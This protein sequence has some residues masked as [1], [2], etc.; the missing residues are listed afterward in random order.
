LGRRAISHLIAFALLCAA[1][2]TAAFAKN[3]AEPLNH[4]GLTTLQDTA[5]GSRLM[6]RFKAKGQPVFLIHDPNL[7][8]MQGDIM[9]FQ[10]KAVL[11]DADV[12]QTLNDEGALGR[13]KVAPMVRLQAKATVPTWETRA[14]MVTGQ[15]EKKAYQLGA[16]L[17]KILEATFGGV[18]NRQQ[19]AIVF[20]G[21][22][23]VL[24]A[25]DEFL[26]QLKYSTV[27]RVPPAGK[28][29]FVSPAPGRT[30]TGLPFR[31]QAW[32]ADP[33]E[34]AGLLR[35]S[36]F[37]ELPKGLAWDAA[38]HAL[39]G[40]PEA[41]G[42]WHLTAEA[43]NNTG[44]FDTIGFNLTVRR[45]A[46]PGLAN[47]PKP[48]AVAGQMWTFRAEA[49]D[50]DHEGTQVRIAPVKMPAGMEYD[51]VGRQFQWYPADSLAG[52]KMDLVLL[53]E[54][55]AG[56]KA[57]GNFT[58]KVI[59]ASEM[60]WS[61]GIK[62]ALP[63][64][65]LKQG[66]TYTWEAGASALAWAQQ[67]VTLVGV[68]GPDYTEFR[69][70]ALTLIPMEAGIHTLTFAFDVQGK[71][72]EQTV[73][74]A[75]RPDLAPRFASEVGAWRVRTGQ[76][77]SYR[78]VAVD[79]GGDPV[80]MRAESPHPQLE[81][82]GERLVLKPK[83]PGTYAARL[84]AADPAGHSSAQWVAYKVER[85]DRPTAWFLENRIQ[86]GISTWAITADFG[87]GR[88]GI[89]TPSLDR[90]GI[91]GASGARFWPYLFFGGNLLGRENENLGRRLWV[92]AGLT[93]RMPD[94]KVAAGGIFGR[95]MGEWTFPGHALGKVE[96]EMQGHVNQALVVA[97]TSN[98]QVIYGDDIFG[99]ADKFSKV[100][101]GIIEEATAKDNMVL[102]SRLESWSRLGAGFWAGPGIWREE[103]PNAHRYH[104]RL[105][106][107]L[108][109][110]ARLGDALAMNSLRAGWGGGA[111]WA[112]YWTGR[113]SLNSPF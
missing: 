16:E 92:D 53:L 51:S 37:G 87:T 31:W 112:V 85:A 60:L 17:L 111:G 6:G 103:M 52:Q 81:W 64:D 90:L 65:T 79:E 67:G 99:F 74:L 28:P 71:P 4:Y 86:G 54:D 69:D 42:Q 101:D 34:P 23:L 102:Y 89:F 21:N 39:T 7:G 73:D 32:A 44:A 25:P 93:M 48:V 3:G 45:N 72:L 95:L 58:L 104:Q 107:G 19:I 24:M 96:F 27:R 36:L 105:G 110:Q 55:P 20:D 35:Y 30:F 22:S 10:D 75:V 8:L 50:P 84:V 46:P 41:E 47:P 14:K 18:P 78:P 13:L 56:G 109:Y 57:E 91:K 11:V 82:D 77:A 76:P 1:G 80:S 108:R 68:S 33:A 106:M 62:P 43:R 98:L 59:P 5:I 38:S 88:M 29:Q 100:V 49:V 9:R 63:W 94:N 2:A 15:R 26:D 61:E 40:T 83:T 66:K 113:V 70:G 12:W 97:D